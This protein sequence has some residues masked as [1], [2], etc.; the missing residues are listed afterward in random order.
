MK[1]KTR[2]IMVLIGTLLIGV[3]IGV[4]STN[5]MHFK[6]L[7]DRMK[8]FRDPD[9]FIER[10]EKSIEPTE[11]QREK[12][13]EILY[14]HHKKIVETGEEFRS[15]MRVNSDSLKIQLNSVLTDEQIEKMERLFKRRDR[16]KPD[17]RERRQD[18]PR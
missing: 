6:R 16:F 4:I 11:D 15:R 7:E 12:L 18:V 9:K 3:I 13:R 10:I 2:T 14:A 17:D 1:V 5:L 8:G